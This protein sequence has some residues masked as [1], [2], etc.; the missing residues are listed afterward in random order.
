MTYEISNICDLN[1]VMNHLGSGAAVALVKHGLI[2][3]DGRLYVLGGVA[4]VSSVPASAVHVR[5]FDEAREVLLTARIS[6]LE[7]ARVSTSLVLLCARLKDNV[8]VFLWVRS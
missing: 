3:D 5:L 8:G 1:C 4:D 2:D 7:V 6:P